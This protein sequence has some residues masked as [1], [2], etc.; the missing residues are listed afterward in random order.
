MEI[1][2]KSRSIG[3]CLALAALSATVAG[4]APAVAQATFNVGN[5]IL[6]V[7]TIDVDGRTYRNLQ[8]RLDPDGRLTIVALTGPVAES[9]DFQRCTGPQ[10][11]DPGP[12]G[13]RAVFQTIPQMFAALAGTWQGCD[14]YGNTVRLTVTGDTAE[15]TV[16]RHKNYYSSY[17]FCTYRLTH[18]RY[19]FIDTGRWWM[20]PVSLVCS[21]G[22]G[23]NYAS[24]DDFNIY[25]KGGPGLAT[26]VMLEVDS[27]SVAPV[28]KR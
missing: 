17:S 10:T 20:T 7:P 26:E 14:I 24:G 3:K 19:P 2:L 4:S 23:L 12:Y 15:G 16:S 1:H 11:L 9:P 18:T 6:T 8:A 13:P 25:I 22:D 5:Q 28:R 27:T 21:E